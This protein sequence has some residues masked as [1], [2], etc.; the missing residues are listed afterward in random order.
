[1]KFLCLHG[2]GTNSKI[3]E[4]QTAA[5]RHELG[6]EHRY[7]FLEGSVP[8]AAAPGISSLSPETDEFFEYCD[9]NSFASCSQMVRDLETY[10]ATEGPFDAVM[11]FSIGATI[12]AG[13]MLH[14]LKAE[15]QN[16]AAPT[17]KCAIFF[18]GDIPLDLC[19]W[20]RGQLQKIQHGAYHEL[21]S[22]P[23][24]HI[25][26]SNDERGFGPELSKL[27]VASL[28]SVFVHGAGHEIPGPKDKFAFREIVRCIRRTMD[29]S[30]A[31]Y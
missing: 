28:R 7:D 25:W 3:F 16:G 31:L 13:L 15:A 5:I 30:V 19:S 18:S 2:K 23:T 24:A 17:F 20:E 9:T 29:R 11:G 14:Q 8:C 10:V 1:M 12:A 22:V 21:L 26:G 4:F 27:C 6:P